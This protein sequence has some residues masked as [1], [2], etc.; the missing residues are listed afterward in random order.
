MKTVNTP[1]SSL[2]A[3]VRGLEIDTQLG[4]C[5]VVNLVVRTEQQHEGFIGRIRQ[6]VANALFRAGDR[7]H[8]SH[9]HNPVRVVEIVVGSTAVEHPLA[10]VAD[11]HVVE[12]WPI[13]GSNGEAYYQPLLAHEGV[14]RHQDS[15]PASDEF[16]RLRG[17]QSTDHTHG[18]SPLV[19]AFPSVAHC[20][21]GEQKYRATV[22]EASG[23]K[24]IVVAHGPRTEIEQIVDRAYP[25]ARM[26]SII[27]LKEAAP[28][29]A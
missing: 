16:L 29:A 8:P 17:Q 5:G 25:G 11:P 19:D 27:R 21:P 18:L 12:I 6:N 13:H 20:A 26:V 24:S 9:D 10:N 23:E 3:Y 28:C 1:K 2:R 22:I 4:E 7:C 14:K 15:R